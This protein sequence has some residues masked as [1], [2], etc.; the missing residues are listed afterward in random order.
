MKI[1][2]ISIK[3]YRSIR[4][5]S[6]KTSA[7]NV[8]VGQNNHGKTNFFEAMEWF[9]SGKGDIGSI[10]HVDATEA[11]IEV[12]VEFSG[13]Q[14]GIERITHADN[15]TKLR[16]ILSDSDTMLVKRSSASAKDRLLLH[17][18]SGDWKKQ[19]TGTDSAFNNCI[20]RFEFVEATKNLKD[21]S[22]YKK[23]SPIEQMLG[24]SRNDQ[25]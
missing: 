10:R 20:P 8:F 16:N 19:P 9:Y 17:P 21:V 7:F 3:N 1:S 25:N 14:D 5:V 4:D 24:W 11:E 6:I 15:Q 2:N 22:A 18:S 12:E 23:N 13:V